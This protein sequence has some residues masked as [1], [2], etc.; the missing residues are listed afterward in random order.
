MRKIYFIFVVILIMGLALCSCDKNNSDEKAYI[1]EGYSYGEISGG[2]AC[3]N[4][5]IKNIDVS[6]NGNELSINIGFSTGSNLNESDEASLSYIPSYSVKRIEAPYA[7]AVHV[8]SVTY[9]DYERNFDVSDVPCVCGVF[10]DSVK[11]T[12]YFRFTDDMAFKTEEKQNTLSISA[13]KAGDSRSA[14]EFAY[15]VTAN[16]YDYYR[17]GFIELD[18]SLTPTISREGKILFI[19]KAF[20]QKEQADELL[21]ALIGKYTDYADGFDVIAMYYNEM[22]IY[23]ESL[24]ASAARSAKVIRKNGSESTPDCLISDGHLFAI[25]G[26]GLIYE[27]NIKSGSGIVSEL[28]IKVGSSSEKLLNYEFA[29]IESVK[30]SSDKSKL[31]VLEN[32]ATGSHLY[33][34]DTVSGEMLYD[35]SEAGIGKRISSF[36]WNELG[37]AIYTVSGT[38]SIAI[39]MYD[40]NISDELKRISTVYD[41]I[42]DEGSFELRD[43]KL[44][45]SATDENGSIIYSLKPELGVKS[46]FCKGSAFRFSEKAVAVTTVSTVVA[47]EKGD[48][49]FYIRDLATG[50][51]TVVTKD[52]PVFDFR[53]SESGRYLYYIENTK[54]QDTDSATSSGTS[55]ETDNYPYILHRYDTETGKSETLCNLKSYS[56]LGVM[57]DDI[58]VMYY[59]G[60][61]DTVFVK[62]TY[63]IK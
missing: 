60:D 36:V 39:K 21:Q 16:L 46:K 31:A 47:M 6:Q 28:R 7:L 40:F 54:S 37:T 26:E 12:V 2:T 25:T 24:D 17:D 63:I 34:F 45:F 20:V 48:Y 57:G 52:F 22:P 41:G 56:N 5:N 13:V 50:E 10:F 3:N 58:L 23:D 53:W 29:N 59:D 55:V 49:S 62:S 51:A 33:I 8:D 19:S 1:P 43:G 11:S 27:K 32:S 42:V 38:G 18:Q 35:L 4:V 15:Y 14:D 61:A 9:T 30:F 44:Y